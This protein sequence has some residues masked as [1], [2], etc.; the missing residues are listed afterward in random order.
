MGHPTDLQ[1]TRMWSTGLQVHM[2][3][4]FYIKYKNVF[5]CL[6]PLQREGLNQ[7][8][9]DL[10]MCGVEW[11]VRVIQYQPIRAQAQFSQDAPAEVQS[12]TAVFEPSHLLCKTRDPD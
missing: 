2:K 7:W 9:V 12:G 6:L 5:E 10:V 11:S 4:D 1:T 8:G 3:S